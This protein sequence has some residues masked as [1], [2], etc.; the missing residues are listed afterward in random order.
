MEE[1]SGRVA[2]VTGA[3]SGIGRGMARAFAR[4]GMRLVLADIE[5]GALEAVRAELAAGGA[6]A[7]AVPSD[8]SQAE[9]VEALAQR[10]YQRF[11]AV[12]VLCNNAGVFSTGVTWEQTLDDWRWVLGVNLWGVVH[13]IHSFVPR[14]LDSGEPGHVVS[15]ASGAGLVSLPGTASYNVSK[16][17]VVTLSETMAQELAARGAAIR[18]SVLCPG[19]IKT[20]ITHSQRNRPGTLGASRETRTD[21]RLREM[22]EQGMDPDQV[23]RIVV[24]GIRRERFYI[25]THDDLRAGVERRMR[26]ILE[27]GDPAA[28]RRRR[29][30]DPAVAAA[31]PSGG[32]RA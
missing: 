23:G 18:V 14:M 12:H 3:A 26:V 21:E 27:D 10:A 31:A 6:E 17:A 30:A 16:H 7:L 29:R 13:G 1:L 2:V 11:G 8:V 4:E 19:P 5:P 28:E 32:R 22:L 9:S 20:G 25:L 24:D 15:T